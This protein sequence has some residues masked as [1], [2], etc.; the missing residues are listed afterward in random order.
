MQNT[1]CQ[2]RTLQD[3]SIAIQNINNTPIKTTK[4]NG[5]MN[6]VKPGVCQNLMAAVGLPN[7][8]DPSLMMW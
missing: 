5:I 3:S 2:P 4:Q 8:L 7:A 6:Y 1:M